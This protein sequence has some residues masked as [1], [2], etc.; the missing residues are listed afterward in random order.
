M[1]DKPKLAA[2]LPMRDNTLRDIPA[3]LYKLADAI[4]AQDH[5]NITQCAIVMQGDEG[6]GVFAYG[7]CDIGQAHLLFALGQRTLES[8][9]LDGE[10]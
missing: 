2:V 3:M 1:D 9:Q 6:M 4:K 5:G 7:D 10:D 8:T